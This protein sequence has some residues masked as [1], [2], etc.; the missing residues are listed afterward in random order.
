MDTDSIEDGRNVQNVEA[1]SYAVKEINNDNNILSNLTL[2]FV[3]LDDCQSPSIALARA[4]QF[5]PREIRYH[6]DRYFN[7]E[8]DKSR[9]TNSERT[10]YDV[11]GVIGTYT[12]KLSIVIANVLNLFHLPQISHTATSNLLSDKTRFPYF[13]RMVPPDRYQVKAIASLLTHFGWSHVAIVFSEGNYGGAGVKELQNTFQA[14]KNGVCIED[15]IAIADGSTDIDFYNTLKRL[16]SHKDTHVVVAFVEI[17]HAISISKAVKAANLVNRFTWVGT[18]SLSLI[19][20]EHPNLCDNLPGSISMHP[21][22]FNASTRRFTDHLKHLKSKDSH[23]ISQ[24]PWLANLHT[25]HKKSMNINNIN[26]SFSVRKP[27][28]FFRQKEDRV[29][30][31]FVD[32]FLIDSVYALAYAIDSVVKS[33]CNPSKIGKKSVA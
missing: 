15:A 2:G 13:F 16:D 33:Y 26:S 22:A 11:I 12:S 5:M 24:N 28:C 1:L 18:D 23:E 4:I 25:F 3:V 10:F 17:E 29:R 31:S 21:H 7:D 9:Q 6:S 30:S 8:V 19:L 20:E 27:K 32:A 14:T